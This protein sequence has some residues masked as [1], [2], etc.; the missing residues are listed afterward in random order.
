[1]LKLGPIDGKRSDMERDIFMQI[2]TM[3]LYLYFLGRRDYVNGLTLFEEML[4]SFYRLTSQTVADIANVDYF[5]INSFIRSDCLF[6]T[7]LESEFTPDEI[8]SAAALLSISSGGCKHICLLHKINRAQVDNHLPDYDRARYI[9]QVVDVELKKQRVF[10]KQINSFSD[11]M[12]AIIEA[13]HRF[14]LDEAKKAGL[15]HR[16]SWA[17]LKNFRLPADINMYQNCSVEFEVMSVVDIYKKIFIIR[18]LK[19]LGLEGTPA[20]ICF[21]LDKE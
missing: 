5:K 19:L 16:A 1:M 14:C 21:F 18:Q 11:L 15:K 3:R 12:R 10:L 13:N 4:G 6:T 2:K 17:Y 20:E 7:K 9:E 8:K